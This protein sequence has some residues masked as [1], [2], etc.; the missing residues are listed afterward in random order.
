MKNMKQTIAELSNELFMLKKELHE[1]KCSE[2]QAW[3]LVADV[4]VT[5]ENRE[6]RPN[7]LLLVAH[8]IH[9]IWRQRHP[10]EAI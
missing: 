5:Y 10:V 2:G 3:D 8:N 6:K 7:E 9:A 1:T 4:A